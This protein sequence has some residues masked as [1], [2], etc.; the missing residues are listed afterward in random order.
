MLPEKPRESRIAT[1]DVPK[2]LQLNDEN[3]QKYNLEF[4]SRYFGIEQKTL[5]ESL[6]NV[7]FLTRK[8]GKMKFLKFT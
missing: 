6:E 5:K 7:S 2:V 8:D 1:N 4:F 3:P